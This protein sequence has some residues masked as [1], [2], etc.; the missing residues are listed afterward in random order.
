MPLS[1]K[2]ALGN[3]AISLIVLLI[4]GF[5][6]HM[7]GSVALFSDAL[8]SVIN[9]VT[10]IA[11]IAAIRYAAEPA[12]EKHPYGHHK[13]EYL[14]AVVVGVLIVLAG[15]TI[16]HEAYNSLLAPKPI[17][18]PLLGV[19]ISS[20]AT[21]LNAVW[22]AVLI[23]Q[24]RK[25]YSPALVADG[26]HLFADVVTSG[27]VV[28]GVGLVIVTGIHVLDAVIAGL[29]ALHVL[30][31]G[32][33]VFKENS[34]SLLDETAPEDQ[35]VAIRKVLADH[36]Q[37]AI[38]FHDLRTR[39]AGKV[40]FIDLHLVVPGDM[41]VARSHE[42]CDRI[43]AALTEALLEAVVTIHVEPHDKAE[44]TADQ[45]LASAP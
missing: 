18:A 19:G 21:A 45:P 9:V 35:L 32:W 31:S 27:G 6:W 34:G 38:E 40:T 25:H 20:I 41:T 3:L 23:R 33:E 26:K 39:Y 30:W 22:S 24:G 28:V 15:V 10:A 17:D 12:D 7:T 4:K 13:A 16:L 29:V 44:K 43:E 37:D 36:A 5:A 8:E 1:R 14:S 42:I 11:A 2:I